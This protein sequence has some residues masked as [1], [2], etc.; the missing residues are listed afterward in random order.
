M[1]IVIAVVL[2]LV[3]ALPVYRWRWAKGERNP[4]GYGLEMLRQQG[5]VACHVTPEGHYRWRTDDSL[6]P[7]VEVIR[8]AVLNGRRVASGFPAKMPAY[9]ARLTVEKWQGAVVAVAVLSGLVGVPEDP[10]LGAGHDVALQMGCFGCHGA[11]GAGGVA[12]PGSLSGAVPGWY[13]KAYQRAVKAQGGLAQLL[14]EGGQPH[15]VPFPGLPSPLLR[16]PAYGN[17]LDSTESS[18]LVGYIEWLNANPPAY[19]QSSPGS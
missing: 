1:W 5:C 15:R 3:A 2:A 7:S 10:E 4:L 11:L 8:D 12:N 9:G 14:R 17:Q 16:M 19:P 6:P 18:L 13:G